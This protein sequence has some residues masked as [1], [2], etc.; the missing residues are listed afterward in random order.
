VSSLDWHPET[1]MLLSASTDRGVIVWEESRD[2][3]GLKPQLAVIKETKSNIDGTWNHTGKKFAVGSSSGNVFIGSYNDAVGFWVADTISGKKPLHSQSVVSVRFDPQS[4]RV[5]ASGSVDGKVYITSC[6]NPD[7]DASQTKGPFGNVSTYGETLV[8]FNA[9]GWV[10][11]VSFSSCASVLSYSTHDCEINFVDVSKS[12]SAEAGKEKPEKVLYK[13]NPFLCGE[14]LNATTYVACGFDKVPFLF[15]KSGSG[16]QFVKYLDE[17][18]N[19]EKQA[20]IAKG[21]FEESQVFFKKSETSKAT[22][23]GLDDDVIMREMNTR[24]TNYINTLKTYPGGKLT[25]SDIN[26]Y[27]NFWDTQGL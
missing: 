11:F 2:V 1:N 12:G 13:G 14:F 21:S 27:L 9:I 15:K 17:G 19:K 8:S 3:N 18:I 5:V 24:H 16:W 10:N 20:Q 23:L 25:T 6:F 22:A 26:G 4:G 7:I